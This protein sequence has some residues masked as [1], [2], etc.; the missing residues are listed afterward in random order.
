MKVEL[1]PFQQKALANLRMRVN[2]AAQGYE[3]SFTP[4]IVSFTAP[5]GAGK[6]IIMASLMESIFF[7]DEL[8][9]EQPNYVGT[10]YFP[11]QPEAIFVWLSDS[12]ELNAQSR[13]KIDFKADKINLNQCVTIDDESF[14]REILEDGHIY[15]LNTQKLSKSSNLTKHSDTRQFT[16]WETLRNT[17]VRKA[18]R[19]YFIIDEAHRGMQGKKAGEAT[20]IMQKFIFGSPTDELPAMPIVIGMSATPERFNA[21]V[22][23]TDSTKHYVVVTPDEVRASGLLKDRIVIRFPEMQN[24]GNA[25]AVLQAAADE[26]KDKWDHWTQY[27]QEQHYAYVNPVFV[28]QVE[29]GS[30]DVISETDLD[31]CLLKISQRTGFTFTSGEVVHTFGQ[32][33]STLQIAGLDVPYVEPSRISDNR[34]IKVV[35][36]KENLSTGWDCPRAETMMSFRKANDATYIAQLLGR[37]VRT[38]MQMHINVDDSL[39]DVHLYLPYFDQNT[40]ND[41][42]EQLNSVEGGAIPADIDS[43]QIGEKKVETLSVRPRKRVI[44]P[45]ASLTAASVEAPAQPVAPALETVFSPIPTQDH[46]AQRVISSA[47]PVV[48]SQPAQQSVQE[49]I[50]PDE[51]DRW[52]VVEAINNMGLLTYDIRLARV[53]SYLTAL[54]KMARL[55]SQSGLHASES[56][57]VISAIV[58]RIH[59]HIENLKIEGK[60]DALVEKHMQVKLNTQVFDIFGESVDTAAPDLFTTT[61]TDIDRQFRVAES[62]LG[63][64]GV[65]NEYGRRFFDED[66]PNGYKIDVIIFALDDDCMDKLNAFA[67]A[68]YQRLINT[69]RRKMTTVDQR[70][71]AQYDSIASNADLVSEHNYALPFDI[72]IP[73]DPT[74]TPCKDHLFVNKLGVAQIKLNGWEEGVLNEERMR[75]DFVCWLRNPNRDRPWALKIPYKMGNETKPAFPDFIIIRKDDDTPSGFVVDILEPHNPNFTDNLGKAQGFAEYARKN[76]DLGRIQLIRKMPDSTGTERF[77]R[78]DMAQV[79]IQEKV[80]AARSTD[81]IDAIFRDFGFFD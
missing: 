18:G 69:Y 38:P 79:D 2:G 58:D 57:D 78:L 46:P 61:D 66:N 75:P 80:L 31:D 24:G 14:D 11:E 62:K 4:Q 65:A 6:T 42:V 52:A 64:E 53:G 71:K 16:I 36:F 60:Y 13:M 63:K 44:A 20:S 8:Y 43:E 54:Y 48:V 7:G 45:P 33:S 77:K 67:K 9:I 32:T 49:E 40:V 37:M 19:L 27:C 72:Q 10:R 41:I 30:G 39:N 50:I 23:K 73:V 34:N 35:F 81:D 29:N 68:W 51:F 59:E 28:V 55:I 22:G 56:K 12:P 17:A 5:T 1:F 47:N 25:M 74:G 21:L 3:S 15:F 26:W 76:P 70:Y